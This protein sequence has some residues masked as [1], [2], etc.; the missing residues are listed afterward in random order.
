MIIKKKDS[1][2]EFDS[3]NPWNITT[4]MAWVH[5]NELSWINA[6]FEIIKDIKVISWKVYF[7]FANLKAIEIAERQYEK[8][9]NRCFFEE[10]MWATYEDNRVQEII[11][12]LKESD[13]LLDIHNTLNTKNS[14]PFLISEYKELWDIFDVNL[15][16]SWFDKLHPWW[17]DGFMNKIWKVWICLESWSIYDKKWPKIAKDGI[18]NFLKYTWNIDW[19]Y[20]IKKNKTFINFDKIY[21]NE[22][23]NFKFV[24]DFLDFEK[25]SL[26]QVIAYDGDKKITSDRD[27]YIMFTYNPK[28]IQD[29]CFC[30][31]KEI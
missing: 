17:S 27:W 23:L 21:K 20:T 14:I 12:Y 6:I 19:K 5:G 15:I 13:Y 29:E 22:S 28:N 11:P 7:I 25:I 2:I 9:M 3:N 31:G 24:K 8:N 18:I 30:L 1:I 4:I 16:I 10:K 26:W